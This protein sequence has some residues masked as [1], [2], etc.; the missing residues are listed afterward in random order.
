MK[1]IFL[2]ISEFKYANELT[3]INFLNVKKITKIRISL[4]KLKNNFLNFF[5]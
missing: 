3:E 5:F 2:N 4:Q 1:L